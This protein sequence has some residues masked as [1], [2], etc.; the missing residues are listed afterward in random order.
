MGM[1][2][3]RRR[4]ALGSAI[5][6][7]V[8]S[9]VSV[10]AGSVPATAVTTGDGVSYEKLG[11]RNDGTI[12]LPNVNGDF[13]CD[14]ADYTPGNLGPG[15][16]ELDLVPFRAIVSAGNSAP[17]SQTVAFA[18]AVDNEDA[19]RPG[20]DFLSVPVLNTDLSSG[21]CGTLNVSAQQFATPGLGGADVTLYRVLT[22]TG[23]Q[24]DSECVYD[25]FARLALGSHV[26]PGASLH[27][28][29]ANDQLGTGGI[30]SKEISIP[31]KEILP[32]ELDKDMTA[33]QGSDHVWN[34]TKQ[35]TP[36]SVSFPDTCDPAQPRS[37]GVQIVVTW[38]KQPATP[39]GPIT[40]VTHVY[41]TNPAA[42][43]ITVSG[44]DQI[45]SGT[46]VLD[47]APWGPTDVPANTANFLL[48]THTT[49]VPAGTTDLNDVA[50]ATYTDKVTGIPVPGS[51]TATASAT[52]QPGGPELNQTA[53]IT[54]VESISGAGLSYS[55]DSFSGASGAFDGGYVAG[56]TTTGSVSWTSASQSDSG[57]VTFDKTVYSTSGN[58]ASGTLSDTAT[59]TGSDGF[60]ASANGSI[61]VSASAFVNLTINKRRSPVTNEDLTFDFDVKDSADVVVASPSITIPGGTPATTDVSTT[62]TGLLPGTYTVDDLATGPYGPQ[63]A[64]ATIDLPS[65]SG[66]VSFNNVAAPAG[67]RVRKITVPDSGTVWQFTLSGPDVGASG[68]ETVNATAGAGYVNFTS[69]LDTDGATYT[70]TETPLAGYDLTA[71]SGDFNGDASRATTSIPSRT[72]S[73]V[74][75][76]PADS[77]GTFSCTFTNTQRGSITIIKN[78]I[79]DDEQ[80]FQYVSDI[81]NF[82]LDDDPGDATLSNTRNFNNLEPGDYFVREVVPVTGWALTSLACTSTLGTSTTVNPF[83]DNP[84]GVGIDLAAGDHV[85]CTFTNT[86][87]GRVRLIKTVNGAPPTGDQAFTFQLRQGASSTQVGTILETEVANAAN[88]GVV[89]FTTYLVPGQTY[90]FCE[91]IMPGWLSTLGTFVPDSFMPPDGVVPNPN[92]DNSIVC[93][94][95]TV[96]PGETRTFTVDNTPP[97]GGRALTIGFWKNWS[98][99][100]GGGQEPVLDETLA[101]F[102]GGGV[103]IGDLFVDT[104]REAVRILNKSTVN[105]GKKKASDPAF[106]LAAQ[107][108]AAKL[109]VQA[110][111]GVCPAAVTAINSAQS[112]LDAV[113]FNG[114]T[115]DNLT[116]AQANQMNSLANTLDRY[117]NNLL[118]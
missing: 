27:W 116:K 37:A 61:N 71:V 87:Q 5:A 47:T 20:Y 25:H 32:Q 101:S 56:T 23:L 60:S 50:T 55:V 117:N 103:L 29:L 96:A 13:I 85:T 90:Q 41:A 105:S 99:C 43:I 31:V 95:F 8:T 118:C 24:K 16:N 74:L 72:C 98:S 11:C 58:A 36:A 10:I 12:V 104:C 89:D 65:C 42:R 70:I 76:Q 52:V 54:D 3:A 94:N 19:G 77:G 38:E 110:G 75:D 66:Q 40:V 26:Y 39:S 102:P 107:L 14:D 73:F 79:P 2:P 17:A 15:W 69:A 113:N 59:L 21:G 106:N 30:G 83:L 88:G 4:W 82:S 97:P 49:T 51:T 84:A 112:L 100:S 18:I 111:A 93:V 115:H 48:L 57:S 44:S 62:V 108:L 67:A 34:I 6:L 109:N 35:P 1:S 91:I 68:T 46:T 53:T 80:D 64:Q 78:A 22:I 28:N 7:A 81:A 9:F 45:R 86:K 33:T 92:V 114:I 63:S